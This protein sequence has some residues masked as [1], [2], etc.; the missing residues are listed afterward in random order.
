[1]DI[2]IK[3]WIIRVTEEKSKDRAVL[4]ALDKDNNEYT[5]RHYNCNNINGDIQTDIICTDK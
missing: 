4:I 3:K 2:E 1:M 5:F